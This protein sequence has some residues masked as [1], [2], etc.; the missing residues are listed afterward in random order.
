MPTRILAIFST[1]LFPFIISASAHAEMVI[2]T[3]EADLQSE[4]FATFSGADLTVA[5]IDAALAR[6]PRDSITE[7][8]ANPQHLANLLQ[9]L[10][11]PRLLFERARDQN[12]FSSN[13]QARTRMFLSAINEGAAAYRDEFVRSRTLES[14]EQRARELWLS[15]PEDFRG[16]ASVDFTHLLIQTGAVRGGVDAMR[17][18]LEVYDALQDGATLEDLIAEFS[19]DPAA[20]DNQGRYTNVDPATLEPAVRDV[21][22][23]AEIG[24][25]SQPINSSIGWHI[26]RLDDRHARRNLD[27][28]EARPLALERARSEHQTRLVHQLYRELLSGPLELADDALPRLLERYGLDVHAAPETRRIQEAAQDLDFD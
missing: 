3:L 14:Y 5:E 17:R 1:L 21:L 28:E 13:E 12:F 22:Q 16:S 27:W 15:R 25:L 19:E 26:V 2:R 10:A 18:V 20:D 23:A 8:L 4:R 6:G 9:G 24:Q 7:L 11:L